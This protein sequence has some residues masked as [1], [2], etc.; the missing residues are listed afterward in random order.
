MEAVHHSLIARDYRKAIFDLELARDD[1]MKLSVRDLT[2]FAIVL[3]L[4]VAGVAILSGAAYD[5]ICDPLPWP[6][7]I[8]S[9]HKPLLPRLLGP[10][11]V[12]LLIAWVISGS[13]V[14][15]RAGQRKGEVIG[16]LIGA[17]LALLALPIFLAATSEF[18]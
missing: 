6:D 4:L 1:P 14:G 8:E 10:I 9:P 13:L 17:I 3:P 15:R 5:F 18:F 2:L 11:W 12:S 16:A 7:G